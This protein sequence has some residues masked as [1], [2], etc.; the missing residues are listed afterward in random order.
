MVYRRHRGRPC[1]SQGRRRRSRQRASEG[2]EGGKE[3]DR[4]GTGEQRGPA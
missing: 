3:G 2:G 4:R 1:G